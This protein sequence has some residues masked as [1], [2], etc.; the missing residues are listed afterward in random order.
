MGNCFN[1]FKCVN[2]FKSVYP[3]SKKTVKH[4]AIK[5]PRGKKYIK[6]DTDSKSFVKED[7]INTW[8][9]DIYS[10]SDWEKWIAYNDDTSKIGDKHTTK[11]HCKGVVAWNDTRISWLCHSAPNFPHY[12]S[13]NVISEIE[14]GELI[15]GQSFQYIEIPYSDT[16]INDILLQIHIMDAHIFIENHIPIDHMMLD[17]ILPKVSTLK[18]GDDM[19][20]I[21]KP[22]NC[23]IDIYG[24][25]IAKEYNYVWRV[26]TWIR[27]HI[28]ENHKNIVD[29]LNIRHEEVHYTETQDHS[30]WAV[31]DDEFYWIGDLNRMTSQYK[32]GGGGF[33]CRDND[34]ASAFRKII[35]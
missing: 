1:C 21:A 23:E 32:R 5:F 29:I 14:E 17:S 3:V 9:A 30:K 28:I 18:I 2:C 6:Y 24:E 34:V 10:K 25:H 27:G 7:D 26:E 20:H 31:S 33:M 13:G 4:I 22:P 8:I 12:F 15:Y 19:T 11:G 35:D 16:M